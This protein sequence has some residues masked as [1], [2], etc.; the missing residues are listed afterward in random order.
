MAR[1]LVSS[2]GKISYA[3][4][5]LD[6]KQEHVDKDQREMNTSDILCILFDMLEAFAE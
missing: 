4:K 1:M 5:L 6:R 2:L 3:S